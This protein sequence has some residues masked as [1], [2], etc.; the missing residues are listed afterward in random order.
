M[1]VNL[2]R[3]MDEVQNVYNNAYILT[4]RDNTDSI[5]LARIRLSSV[6]SQV[7]NKE[8]AFYKELNIN[9]GSSYK[10]FQILNTRI[11]KVVSNSKGLQ[12]LV[13]NSEEIR[14]EIITRVYGEGVDGENF[15]KTSDLLDIMNNHQELFKPLLKNLISDKY[16]SEQAVQSFNMAIKNTSQ[17]SVI[18]FQYYN[19]GGS[20]KTAGQITSGLQGAIIWVPDNDTISGETSQ[21]HF[22]LK[23]ASRHLSKDYKDR[24]R[25]YLENRDEQR[26]Q[27][28]REGYLTEE[29]KNIMSRGERRANQAA[30][31]EVKKIIISKLR[32][33]YRDIGK[34]IINN[35]GADIAFALEKSQFAGF[36]GEVCSLII[37]N[38]LLNRS[39]SD[40]QFSFSG[41]LK[42]IG[43]DVLKGKSINVDLLLGTWGFQIKNYNRDTGT[44]DWND[45]INSYSFV[46][47]RA[48]MPFADVL[49]A[50]FG[51]LYYNQPFPKVDNLTLLTEDSK[52]KFEN[53]KNLYASM[54][55]YADGSAIQQL[56]RLNVDKIIGLDKILQLQND[57]QPQL[58]FNA[59]FNISGTYYPASSVLL[60][61]MKEL[62]ILEKKEQQYITTAFEVSVPEDGSTFYYDVLEDETRAKKKKKR[63]GKDG[64]KI[65]AYHKAL[66]KTGKTIV[67]AAKQTKIH[68]NVSVNFKRIMDEVVQNAKNW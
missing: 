61:L 65:T 53:Y 62:E 8:D 60:A 54:R 64:S 56:F 7:K 10:N 14:Q 5:A 6:L 3:S 9:G 13:S 30:L 46:M 68:Y 55:D 47:G 39:G 25:H 44:M 37:I 36:M 22:E 15:F 63:K 43:D 21:G 51:T 20:E 41:N 66:R 29:E 38:L 19:T 49:T 23:D 17:A 50:F 26:V 27:K 42:H 57:M 12:Y 18:K 31:D 40:A 34:A 59:F 16:I 24:I 28:N 11:Q 45:T 33:S 4:S 48:Q 2:C 35:M 52:N 67:W 58:Y 1:G 32:G